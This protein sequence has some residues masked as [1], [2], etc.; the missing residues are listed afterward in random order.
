MNKEWGRSHSDG[1]GFSEKIPEAV[2]DKSK[3]GPAGDE[4]KVTD[5]HHSR[6]FRREARPKPESSI[7]KDCEEEEYVVEV[8]Q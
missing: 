7:A 1:A 5:T 8:F 4:A 3:A 2:D 6:L